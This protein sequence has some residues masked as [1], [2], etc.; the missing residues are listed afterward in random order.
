[1]A[2]GPGGKGVPRGDEDAAAPTPAARGSATPAPDGHEASGPTDNTDPHPSSRPGDIAREA[3]RAARE[4]R[5]RALAREQVEA[6]KRPRRDPE[7]RI[8]RTT[9]GDRAADRRAREIRETLADAFR[10][11]DMAD[12]PM[13]DAP[14]RGPTAE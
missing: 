13:P 3:L 5:A 12:D 8:P 11:P 10:M 1:M 2:D 14:R 9:R 4:E 7:P 6:A